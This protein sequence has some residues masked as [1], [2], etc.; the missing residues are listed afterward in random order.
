MCLIT[1]RKVH[2]TNDALWRYGNSD[3]YELPENIN[4]ED[5]KRSDLAFPLY[6][7]ISFLWFLFI[8]SDKDCNKYNFYH[9]KIWSEL[10]K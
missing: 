7:C 10:I 9:S 3:W 4:C 8:Y 2:F 5:F 6:G 1:E